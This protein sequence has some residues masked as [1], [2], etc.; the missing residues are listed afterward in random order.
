MPIEH[1][2]CFSNVHIPARAYSVSAGYADW[3]AEKNVLKIIE[4]RINQP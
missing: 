3:S 2:T 4:W 1:K